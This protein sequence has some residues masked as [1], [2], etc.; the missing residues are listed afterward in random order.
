[1]KIKEILSYW[2]Q[3][4]NCRNKKCRYGCKLN[5]SIAPHGP[6]FYGDVRTS[7]NKT[8]RVYIGRDPDEWIDA[9]NQDRSADDKIEL[10]LIPTR[11]ARNL[12]AKNA[13]KAPAPKKPKAPKISPGETRALL[14]LRSKPNAK[15]AADY[16]GLNP[17]FSRQTL[18]SAFRKA[19]MIAHP[20]KEGTTS[21]MSALNTAN[22]ILI[23]W[24]K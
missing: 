6:Y 22:E 21:E 13:T 3:M 2:Q 15:A 24:A 14:F 11:T 19:A 12:A 8:R 4:I 23:R 18:K 9:I 5:P 7:Q 10:P 1:M 20:D 16:L 17:P